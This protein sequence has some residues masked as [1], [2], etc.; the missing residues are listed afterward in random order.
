MSNDEQTFIKEGLAIKNLNETKRDASIRIQGTVDVESTEFKEAFDRVKSVSVKV[1]LSDEETAALLVS[2][3][4]GPL[5][6][7]AWDLLSQYDEIPEQE[8]E[9]MNNRQEAFGNLFRKRGQR[10]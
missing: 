5:D 10:W 3:S 8:S 2:L 6:T 4:S 9:R 1:G 7:E